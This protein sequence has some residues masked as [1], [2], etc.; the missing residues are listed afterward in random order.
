MYPPGCHAVSP[1]SFGVGRG[2]GRGRHPVTP[3]TGYRVPGAPGASRDVMV[4]DSNRGLCGSG[5]GT[6]WTEHGV[7][8]DDVDPSDSDIE[9]D[10]R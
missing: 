3:P 7:I 4:P 1:P 10:E 6:K 8:F 2:R 5:N 9:F